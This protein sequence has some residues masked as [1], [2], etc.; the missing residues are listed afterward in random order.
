MPAPPLDLRVFVPGDPVPKGN[1]DGFPIDRGPCQTCK[2]GAPCRG[3]GCF[4]GRRVGVSITDDGGKALE[5]W[6][7]LVRIHAI[8]ARNVAGG[9]LVERPG[10]VEVSMVFLRRRPKTHLKEGGGL[11]SDGMRTP[12]PSTKPDWDKLAR[13]V[14]D[15][16]TSATAKGLVGAIAE[17]DA[18]ICV[19]QVAKVFTAGRPGVIIR[20][21]QI[22]APPEWVLAEMRAV[23]MDVPTTQGALL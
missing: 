1:H 22:S 2:P 17:D 3:R 14:G 10:A 16:L 4:G 19:A 15:G 13:A 8:S 6:Q 18:Q 21:R 5:A 9:R 23:G 11:S 20:A 7:G 12:L